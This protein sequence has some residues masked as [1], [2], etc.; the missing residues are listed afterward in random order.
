MS[1]DRRP[2]NLRCSALVLREDA[3]LLCRRADGWVLPGGTPA[4]DESAAGCARRET[5]EET[6]LEVVPV[7]VAF[8]LDATN[9]AAGQY[10]MEIVFLAHADDKSALPYETEAGLV[11]EFVP[12]QRL[13]DL[14]LR[15]PIGKHIQALHRGDDRVAAYL[16]NVWE[17]SPL[18]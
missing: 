18:S 11:P 7:G 9:S 3:V 8:V 5:L 13:P 15:P 10:L 16:G 12:L 17:P 6:G 1:T 14:S 2:V 4:G